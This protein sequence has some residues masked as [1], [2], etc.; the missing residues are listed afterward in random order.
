MALT[1][2][3]ELELLE[4]EE[5][6]YQEST[7]QQRK[8]S[9]LD[10]AKKAVK[11]GLSATIAPATMLKKFAELPPETQF[12]YGQ[13]AMPILGGMVGGPIGAAGGEF[14]R[15]AVGTA[16]ESPDVP[17]TALG[18]FSGVVGQGLAMA[19]KMLTAIPGVSQAGEAI[20]SGAGRLGRSAG[21][22]ATKAISAI[23]G[24]R[25]PDITQGF[26]QGVSTYLAPGM[27]KAQ[28]IF[29]KG[30][31]AAGISGKTP[32]KQIVDPQLATARKVAIE[33]GAKLEKSVSVTAEEALR[34]RQAVDR[35]ISATK[36]TDRTA[37]ADLFELRQS[38][39]DALSGQ[40]GAM[41]RASKL[42]RK[43]IVKSNLLTPLKLT[44]SG[45]YSAVVPI[46]GALSASSGLVS[47]ETRSKGVGGA[48]GLAALT[49]P[50]LYG[51]GITATGSLAGGLTKLATSPQAR[52][53]GVTLAQKLWERK[54]TR[55]KE[56]ANPQ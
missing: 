6:E 52:Q 1:P 9:Y 12:K 34:A 4:L 47:P 38:F 11:A 31:E 15:Q 44:K 2:E 32:L 48:L 46:L 42:Y 56:K 20:A 49:S 29:K 22:V 50:A 28:E 24:L 45:T 13:S 27:E 37:R 8:P 53:L 39:D 40:S 10:T 30:L 35:I 23:T 41:E 18:A 3:E 21:K 25:E 14:A 33:I 54:Q 51:A 17:K 19:P 5:E 55:E 43:A 36:L 7:K 26:R 16:L